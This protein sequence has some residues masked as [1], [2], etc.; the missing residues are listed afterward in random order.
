MC[1]RACPELRRKLIFATN[2]GNS[3]QIERACR[4]TI[5]FRTKKIEFELSIRKVM[6]IW[7]DRRRTFVFTTGI[8]N[9]WFSFGK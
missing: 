5:I 8:E 2:I 4:R 3:R 9:S 1:G 6:Q 7:L